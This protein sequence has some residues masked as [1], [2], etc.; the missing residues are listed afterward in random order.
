MSSVFFS[1]SFFDVINDNLS[2]SRTIRIIFFDFKELF[3]NFS[4]FHGIW[5]FCILADKY[6]N[7]CF[8]I[9]RKFFKSS[10]SNLLY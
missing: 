9:N 3:K 7:A 4:W 2:K 5:K 6:G 1:F 10:L 8:F